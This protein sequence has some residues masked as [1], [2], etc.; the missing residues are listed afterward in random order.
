MRKDVKLGL[1]I[2]AIFLAVV[3]V[4]AAVPKK[5]KHTGVVLNSK[6]ATGDGA[7]PQGY[8]PADSQSP[9]P[10][11]ATPNDSHPAAPAPGGNTA[12]SGGANAPKPSADNKTAPDWAT[13]L[14]ASDDQLPALIGQSRVAAESADRTAGPSDV[15]SPGD[16]TADA[17]GH[18]GMVADDTALAGSTTRPA[19]EFSTARTHTVQSGETLASIAKS[20]YGKSNMYLA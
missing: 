6:L 18:G 7:T 12:N 1:A 5:P 14:R 13:L 15:Q 10:S 9:A 4:W 20:V 19:A 8:S 16:A 17:R 3:I 2:G 11:P